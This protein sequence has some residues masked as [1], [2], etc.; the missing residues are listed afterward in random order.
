MSVHGTLSPLA[1]RVRRAKQRKARRKPN[2]Q[3]NAKQLRDKAKPTQETI[4]PGI[5]A[6]EYATGVYKGEINSCLRMRQQATRWLTSL[7]DKEA[8]YVPE[9][10]DD[11]YAWCATHLVFPHGPEQ[12]KPFLLSAYQL[13][14][15]AM[16]LATYTDVK[17]LIPLYRELFWITGKGT[18]KTSTTAA[19][20]LERMDK[21]SRYCR[22][23]TTVPAI[24]KDQE[25]AKQTIM[26]DIDALYKESTITD[27]K[28]ITQ[29]QELIALVND[30]TRVKLRAFT[31]NSTTNR[32]GMVSSFVAVDEYTEIPDT[33]A[34]RQARLGFKGGPGQVWYLSNGGGYVEYPAYNDFRLACNV[35]DGAIDKP[36][37]CPV[38]CE[39][40]D[41]EQWR[42][43]GQWEKANPMLGM[44]APYAYYEDA[45]KEV[46]NK[47][48]L[49]G[50][51]LRLMGGKW[52][53]AKEGWI[54]LNTWVDLVED[55]SLTIEAFDGKFLHFALDLSKRNDLSCYVIMAEDGETDAGLP[56]YIGMLRAFTCH[57]LKGIKAKS[58]KDRIDYETLAASELIHVSPGTTIDYK[59]LAEI[60]AADLARGANAALAADTAY[61]I[62]F[63]QQAEGHLPADL[64]HHAHPQSASANQN[65][66]DKLNMNRSIREAEDIIV[67][68]RLRFMPNPL[69]RIALSAVKFTQHQGGLRSFARVNRKYDPAVCLAMGCGFVSLQGLDR[70]PIKE[71]DPYRGMKPH[72]MMQLLYEDPDIVKGYEGIG[73]NDGK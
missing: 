55:E 8:T 18:S 64:A 15:L 68:G 66:P 32:K 21:D 65:Y 50:D 43:R 44:G 60:M 51:H 56:K 34:I 6:F 67:S 14:V 26:G 11:F 46:E 42:E 27:Y 70:G 36:E 17:R 24:C 38:I 45:T 1:Q 12:G 37:M 41:V 7:L 72:E 31:R 47:P 35:L 71:P 20:A 2:E 4:T 28:R 30:D 48:W 22:V 52:A 62:E 59:T 54:D 63:M 23:G 57:G 13:W 58:E 69:M 10:I 33:S 9:H 16:M 5:A 53:Q 25:Q 49:L 3:A 40:D 19:V 73:D 39:F 29:N 61:K